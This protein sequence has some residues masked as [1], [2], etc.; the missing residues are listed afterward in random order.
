M[1]ADP[2]R[3]RGSKMSQRFVRV[4][5]PLGSLS[6]WVLSLTFLQL[7]LAVPQLASAMVSITCSNLPRSLCRRDCSSFCSADRIWEG[8]QGRKVTL[9]KKKKKSNQKSCLAT[10]V[11]CKVLPGLVSVLMIIFESEADRSGGG[12]T[13]PPVG[14]P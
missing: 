5:R 4:G 11:V 7:A 8:Q 10:A 13:P 6:H 12:H 3:R 2:C 9:E 1:T 14:C